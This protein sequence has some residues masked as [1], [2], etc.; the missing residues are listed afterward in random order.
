MTEKEIIQTIEN[1]P[2]NHVRFAVTD[3]D[4][5]LRGKI[6]NKQKFL[7]GVEE[8]IGFCN[9][10][11]GWDINDDCYD[12]GDVSGWNT[13]YPDSFAILD[14]STFRL[15]PWN[16]D[17]PFF[18]ADFSNAKDVRAACPRT[19]LKTIKQQATDLGYKAIFS[20]EFEWFN[21]KETPQSLKDKNLVNP[22]PFTPGMFGTLYCALRKTNLFTMTC[23]IY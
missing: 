1:S 12:K 8:G 21:F 19:L 10:I 5:V 11:F 4:G 18:L 6:I 14:L 13:G 17:V 7:K 2:G 22:Q 3:V 15:V 20:K 16:D 23:L 9:V